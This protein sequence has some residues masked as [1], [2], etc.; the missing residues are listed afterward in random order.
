M[1]MADTAP[2]V[3]VDEHHESSERVS[4]KATH[5]AKLIKESSHFIVFTGAGVS[6]SAGRF[7]AQYDSHR[8]EN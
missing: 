1:K 7:L 8:H 2:K 3:A 4:R 5:L 6:T